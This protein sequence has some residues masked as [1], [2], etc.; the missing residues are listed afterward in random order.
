VVS[1]S[2]KILAKAKIHRRAGCGIA[3]AR[4]RAMTWNEREIEEYKREQRRAT[5]LYAT[6]AAIGIA[7]LGLALL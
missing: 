5:L 1:L 4:R 2:F 6:L 3:F 7:M